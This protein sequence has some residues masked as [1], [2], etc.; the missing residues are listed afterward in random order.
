M[1]FGLSTL[2]LAVFIASIVFGV[3]V[4]GSFVA[5]AIG[6]VSL[7]VLLAQLMATSGPRPVVVLE[8]ASAVDAHMLRNFLVEHG[9][10]ARVEGALTTGAYPTV[11]RPRVIVPPTQSERAY[12]VMQQLAER[13]AND[14]S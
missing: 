7:A 6:F 5:F 9:V 10:N 11:T 12:A 8:S 2:M 3:T 4:H 13:N 1:K 14:E